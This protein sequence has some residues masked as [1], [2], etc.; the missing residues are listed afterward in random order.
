[1]EIRF[2]H[3]YGNINEELQKEIIIKGLSHSND[4]Y[5]EIKKI[6]SKIMSIPGFTSV[7]KIPFKSYK[8]LVEPLMK[9]ELFKLN[10]LAKLIL[11]GYFLQSADIVHIVTE[12]LSEAGYEAGEPDFE[13]DA[14]PFQ[15]LGEE[16]ILEEDGICIFRPGGDSLKDV[17]DEEGTVIAALLGWTISTFG[18]ENEE[19]G[20]EEFDNIDVTQQKTENIID[21]NQLIE[22]EKS[23]DDFELKTDA[24]LNEFIEVSVLFTEIAKEL[25]EGIIPS[26]EFDVEQLITLN[27][28]FETLKK[29][30]DFNCD[31]GV[32]SIQELKEK[33]KKKKQESTL[34]SQLKIKALE[35]LEKYKTIY[36]I[37]DKSPEFFKE[38]N[39]L[40]E[41][42]QK[43][44][45]E[46]VELIK[47]EWFEKLVAGID[48]F[49]YLIRAVN[50]TKKESYD[51]DELDEIL[52]KIK[53]EFSFNRFKS[54]SQL[55]RDLIRE[56][57]DFRNNDNS[58]FD[59]PNKTT[60]GSTNTASKAIDKITKSNPVPTDK[61]VSAKTG[62]EELENKSDK[63]GTEIK[64]IAK[65]EVTEELQKEDVQIFEGKQIED[66]PDT[67]PIETV[68]GEISV[69]DEEKGSS[70]KNL[71]KE[72]NNILKLL[73]AKET[74]LAYHLAKCYVNEGNRLF[75][76]PHILENLFLSTTLFSPEGAIAEQVALNINEYV[77]EDMSSDV[78]IEK[79]LFYFA[80]LLQPLLFAYNT[81]GAGARMSE[82]SFA[83]MPELR[84]LTRFIYDYMSKYGMSIDL[85]LVS[86]KNDYS[87][88][89]NERK[90]FIDDFYDWLLKAQSIRF[91]S[92]QGHPYTLVWQSWIKEDGWIGLE[93][94][95]LFE[96]KTIKK[97]KNFYENEFKPNWNKQ[98][99]KDVKLF[100]NGKKLDDQEKANV[101]FENQV[102]ELQ[103]Y[104]KK[105]FILFSK[106]NIT[107]NAYD[108]TDVFIFVKS[109][110]TELE[111]CSS[112]LKNNNSKTL[113]SKVAY[114]FALNSISTL[115]N[116]LECSEPKVKLESLQTIRNY[117]LLFLDFYECDSNW[118]PQ[119]H[120]S[121]LKEKIEKIVFSKIDS[122]VEILKKHQEEFNIEAIS[123]ISQVSS[124]LTK[125]ID[126]P[127][128]KIEVESRLDHV[129]EQGKM[130]V[131]KACAL[132]Y[133]GEDNRLDTIAEIDRINQISR[134]NNHG[135]NLPL[136]NFQIEQVLQ[137]LEQNRKKEIKKAALLIKDNFKTEEKNRLKYLLEESN[138]LVF[139]ETLEMI[140]NNK[141]ENDSQVESHFLNFFNNVISQ[142][143]DKD[144]KEVVSALVNRNTIYNIN[145][146]GLPSSQLEEAKQL[147]TAW[148]TIKQYSIKERISLDVNNIYTIVDNIG[149]KDAKIIDFQRKRNLQYY[150]FDCDP[151]VDKNRCP[152]PQF[153][154]IANGKYRLI[155]IWDG[156][157]EEELIDD[158]KE[159]SPQT[160]RA[161]I[162]FSFYKM[163]QQ[164]RRDL[165][166]VNRSYK[167]SFLVLDE[168]LL[169]YLCGIRGSRLPIFFKLTTPFTYVEP[170][171]TS[172]S[173]L[174]Q[175][176]FYGRMQQIQ[177]L[178]NAVGDVS[179]LIY[180]GRQLGKTVLQKEVQRQF[181]NPG[182]KHY[183]IYI[184]LRGKGIGRDREIEEITSVL[185][186]EFRAIPEL[187]PERFQPRTGID[188]LMQ[189]LS[190]W[191]NNNPEGRIIL[192]LDESDRLLEQDAEKEW[193]HLLPLKELMERTEKRFK[194]IFSGLHDVRRTN[195][196]PNNPLAHLGSPICI[197]PM[198]GGEETN[199]AKKLIELPLDTLG[200]QFKK[201]D[202]VYLILSHA[203]WYPSLIQIICS[204]LVSVMY[205][206]RIT[207]SFPQEIDVS[208][209]TEALNLCRDKKKENFGL[210][211][212]LDPSYDLIA[213]II[214]LETLNNPKIQVEGISL[215]TILQLVNYFWPEGFDSSNTRFEVYHFLK[216]MV[217]LGI[218]R[219][220]ND[221]YFSLRTSNIIDLIGTKE[222]IEENVYNK[223]RELKTE[224]KPKISRIL[225]TKD[226]REQR[227][228]FPAS[229]FYMVKDPKSKVLVLKGSKMSG[230]NHIES[231]LKSRNEINLILPDKIITTKDLE[232]FMDSI[233]SRRNKDKGKDDVI[234]ITNQIP[235]GIQQIEY[236]K[237]KIFR[238]ERLYA[239]FLMDPDSIKR[240][241]FRNDKS[242]EKLE[243]EGIKLVNLPN[244][245]ESI[246]EE[247]FKETGCINADLKKIVNSLGYWH[248]LIDQF[249]SLIYHQP[250]RWNEI[251]QNFVNSIYTNKENS[252]AEFG[253]NSNESLQILKELIELKGTAKR[254]E[255]I[256]YQDI[257]DA[258]TANNVIE[259]LLSLNIIDNNLRV[260]HVIEKLMSDE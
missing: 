94:I 118:N 216:E 141:F 136:A 85:E 238:K 209:I 13:A 126:I 240:V 196:I 11:Q 133:L 161:V 107:P 225:F 32:N 146:N 36:H 68:S 143:E 188:K 70:L 202:L 127:F 243:N 177:Q 125:N 158:V 67:G 191:F 98:L 249:H 200:F 154:S 46:T 41:K 20:N 108:P 92:N 17:G 80:S 3:L 82:I 64:Y 66:S 23:N 259:Y 179:C 163:T 84:E 175:E 28:K 197:G 242:F 45:A 29:E 95:D 26:K 182:I 105:I 1:M 173:N 169:I 156:P 148:Y 232:L 147:V 54:F 115:K 199:E 55:S 231:F 128:L 12:K 60:S 160:Y 208:E 194:V 87:I 79:R 226:N 15:K 38:L 100:V 157:T 250:E 63:K 101:W 151:I 190:V 49:G 71:S 236:I 65:K 171:Q 252:L 137:S 204:K 166:K 81:T 106:E 40:A 34:F 31:E 114:Q 122:K 241:I 217:D 174:P 57:L 189:K 91:R 185:I 96:K 139:Y 206:K 234:L 4:I 201:K 121:L 155:C 27:E 113:L 198:I 255:Y 258:I 193:K 149:F 229:I 109:L 170:Y 39:E 97:I 93:L 192:F 167:S 153:G 164:R 135:I 42:Q 222:N 165:A 210:T 89:I 2:L 102:A 230:L 211:L 253:I 214:A 228:P 134:L 18:L 183:S 245:K 16:D 246:I 132:G 124:E 24:L 180:G 256:D 51:D 7:S 88:D 56:N 110:I 112:K 83:Q 178:K 99:H 162:V 75:L 33:Y 220:T 86:T 205:S 131:E 14:L 260:D 251:L 152:I 52:D 181:H 74:Q 233:D 123:K 176:M 5:K 150:D 50:L 22:E 53:A 224:F 30:L 207:R 212:A 90:D 239:V 117:P 37:K 9:S 44:I 145:F 111:V 103:D 76:P 59:D 120:S 144:A 237:N 195:D 140:K 223:K 257:C 62:P 187:I 213:N 159:Y 138:L 219:E 43:E 61:T 58:T 77:L 129:I 69:F 244:W 227:S 10:E 184:D 35:V 73:E 104:L 72:D 254:N 248:S 172:S 221:K 203:N 19:K 247:W 168:F 47:H 8:V 48:V 130:E 235:F 186:E 25:K 116:V 218:L 142:E 6:L 119:K 78:E 215:D 21:K